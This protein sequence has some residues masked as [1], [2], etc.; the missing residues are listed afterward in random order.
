MR[1]LVLGKGKTGS[2]V[3]EIAKDRGHSVISF[4]SAENINAGALTP[5]NLKTLGIDVAVDF[6]TPTAV[7]D[8]IAA[9]AHAKVNMVVG[10]TGWHSE[11]DSVRHLVELNNIGLVYGSNFS[12]GVNVFLDVVRAASKALH[13]GYT[14][15]LVE[16]HHAEKKD[17][18]SGTAATLQKIIAETGGTEPEITSVREGDTIGTHVMLLD[19]EYDTMMLVHDAKSRRGFASGAVRAAEWVHGKKGFYEFK[20]IFSQL[21]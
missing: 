11:L 20:D 6:T 15:K 14:A 17:S 21:K 1:L 5:E 9:C 8:N 18:P 16:R 4:S 2:V 12:V 3:A 7:L 13:F 19:S 10:T